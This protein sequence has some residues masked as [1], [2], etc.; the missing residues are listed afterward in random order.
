MSSDQLSK[1]SAKIK[2]VYIELKDYR[3]FH[4][5]YDES[6]A[7]DRVAQAGSP[8]TLDKTRDRFIGRKAVKERIRS[9]LGHTDT[10]SGSYLI[11]GFRGM[12]K[13]SVIRQAIEEYNDTIDSN[14][15]AL[16]SDRINKHDK[17]LKSARIAII[18]LITTALAITGWVFSL[19]FSTPWVQD[20]VGLIFAVITGLSILI[21]TLHVRHTFTA[22]NKLEVDY[23]FLVPWNVFRL[24]FVIL[25]LIFIGYVFLSKGFLSFSSTGATAVFVIL[26]RLVLA[27]LVFYI[28][29]SAVLFVFDFLGLVR[30]E[31]YTRDSVTQPAEDSSVKSPIADRRRYEKF[32]IN[33]SQDSLDEMDVLRRM[34]IAIEDYWS[35]NRYVFDNTNFDR[36]LYRPWHFFI[37]CINRPREE[38]TAASYKSVLS[39]LSGLRMRMSGQV[40]TRKESRF[41]PNLKADIAGL[42]ELAMPLGSFSNNDEIVF[43]VANAKEAEYQL[44]DILD[45]IDILR[46]T[47][48]PKIPLF[49]F[50]ID[51]LDK[52]EPHTP[53]VK[54]GKETPIIDLNLFDP[55]TD[56][57]R[58]RREAVGKLLANL[59]GFLSVA[60]AKMFFIGGRE[61][62]DADLADI[63]D[64]ESFYSSIFNDVIYVES[65]FKDSS[66]ESGRGSGG[67]T[68]MTEAYVCKIILNDLVG[69]TEQSKKPNLE[70]L[71]NFLTS[72]LDGFLRFDGGTER[73]SPI[74]DLEDRQKRYKVIFTLQNFIIFLTYRSN[75]T[76]K[77]LTSLTESLIVPGPVLANGHKFFRDNLVILHDPVN[78]DDKLDLSGRLFLKFNFTTQYEIGVTANL[79]RPY[80]ITN[81][82]HLKALGDKLLFSSS[83]IIDHILKFHPFAF[84][85]RDLELIPE[86]VLV[87]REPHLREFIDDLIRF[88]SLN[89]IRNTVSGLFE[90]RFRSIIRRDLIHLSKTSDLSAAAFNF[91]L[92]ESL[93][94]KQ[95]YK[96][97]LVELRE[98]YKGAVPVERDNQFVHSL[99]FVQTIL[100][101]LHFYDKEYDAAILYYTESIQTLRLPDAV[102]DLRITRHQFLIWLRNELKLGL[103]LEKIRAYDSAFS[104]YKTLS[105]DTDR[106]LR[107]LVRNARS[108]D[109]NDIRNLYSP[110][111]DPEE[112]EDHRTI[113]LVSMP[114]V[115]LLAVTEKA[116]LDGITYA[117]L[118]A[119]R[120]SFLRTI[121]AVH[122]I[123]PRNND[124]YRKTFLQ[125]DYYNNVGSILY[126][127][128]CQFPKVFA[129]NTEDMSYLL[130]AVA[131][132]G[133]SHPLLRAQKNQYRQAAPKRR[134][135]NDE[136]GR[137]ADPS[138]GYDQISINYFPA[139]TP[140]N[141]YW[142]SLY[143]LLTTNV[144][145]L[146]REINAAKS[147]V[148]SSPPGPV[149]QNKGNV[150]GSKEP[151]EQ[152]DLLALTCGYLLPGCHDLVSDSRLFYLANVISKIGDSILASL[153]RGQ[154]NLSNVTYDPVRLHN[155]THA[156]YSETAR[157]D[158]LL[159][160]KSPAIKEGAGTDG[161]VET[162]RFSVN[163]WNDGTFPYVT[164]VLGT[165]ATFQALSESDVFQVSTVLH[166][167]ELAAALFHKSGQ[168]AYYSSQLMRILYVVKDVVELNKDKDATID[169]LFLLFSPCT[170]DKP[171]TDGGR[172]QV[173]TDNKSA[174]QQ[175]RI[176]DRLEEIAMTIIRNT[177]WNNE[178][179]NRPQ[180]Q[181]YK[182][183]FNLHGEEWAKDRNIIYSNISNISDAKEA[184]LLVESIKLKLAR[185]NDRNFI[186]EFALGKNITSAYGSVNNRYLRM[187][188]LKYR[189]E[190][191]YYILKHVMNLPGL[192]RAPE[193]FTISVS[194]PI[195]N[196]SELR[197]IID[198]MTAIISGTK[199]D[200]RASDPTEFRKFEPV[201]IRVAVEFVIK[202]ALFCSRQLINMIRLYD[203]GYVIGYSFI[204]AAHS[205]MGDWCQAYENHIKLTTQMP[206]C[207]MVLGEI[208]ILEAVLGSLVTKVNLARASTTLPVEIKNEMIKVA[209]ELRG[210]I[211]AFIDNVKSWC[212]TTTP[213]IENVGAVTAVSKELRARLNAVTD[214]IKSWCARTTTLIGET[215]GASRIT[216]TL[217]ARIETF[218]DGM[219]SLYETATA[220]SNRATTLSEYAEKRRARIN[221][222]TGE[223]NSS[224]ANIRTL[225]D[226]A[227]VVAA[228]TQQHRDANSNL[229]DEIK[230]WSA[231]TKTLTEGLRGRREDF[232][233]ETN[234]WF[235]EAKTFNGEL[236]VQIKNF[237]DEMKW[238]C[239]T[240]TALIEEINAISNE[241]GLSGRTATALIEEINAIPVVIDELQFL[242]ESQQL[243]EDATALISENGIRAE[244]SEGFDQ[245]TKESPRFKEEIQEM[246]G[247]ETLLFL[248]PK[249]HYETA[250]LFYRKM[251][252]LHSDGKSY[253][254]KLHD[255][256]MLEDDYNDGSAHYSIAAERLRINTGDIGSKMVDLNAK[257]ANSDLYKYASYFARHP[258]AKPTGTFAPGE[259]IRFTEFLENSILDTPL[260]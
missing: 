173:A 186:K 106:Y 169:R 225:I 81:S 235:A 26:L 92:D 29:L 224:C 231:K 79:Y 143:H 201:S 117:N 208:E 48:E 102:S 23:L 244:E 243:T 41:S 170:A 64:R 21:G 220:L 156:S 58:Q 113:Q 171:H 160:I 104:L 223:I 125:A 54:E 119:N 90:Y 112:A 162:E 132:R 110:E 75:G 217:R 228:F 205:R 2:N 190:R 236:G 3:F 89:Y 16:D 177:T 140:L 20:L 11:T 159:D 200:T 105:L 93:S 95:H 258:D 154:S 37:T 204:A 255:I 128:N 168:N 85:W 167:Y 60:K 67:I 78:I 253:R 19:K 212:T 254:D 145:R 115:A 72:N 53:T 99:C 6:V 247:T 126:Y 82:R 252:Q 101:D 221:M 187:L 166:I 202:E 97:K 237:T 148:A 121:N 214:G 226:G 183:T 233:K 65:F 182:D 59:K 5:P 25:L 189:S 206:G 30:R 15:S 232:T 180:I 68:Q 9:I 24:A 210:L 70:Q 47:Q 33:L 181:K 120:A 207:E 245:A 66:D 43:P 256:Y 10:K 134:R 239:S 198:D 18:Y 73:L 218:T 150:S 240:V 203:P 242:F 260:N 111:A 174:M 122:K 88:Y 229:T 165:I 179:S 135:G 103:T 251:I 146:S 213:L 155:L 49:A 44:R 147:L 86:V 222:F 94:V 131:D 12:G 14:L 196:R 108:D 175:L 193:K 32:E 157:T 250:L 42:A 139:L 7:P 227:D 100:G 107:R 8:K 209:E 74:R 172:K 129:Y 138:G 216:K 63:S 56:R 248:E 238:W 249:N 31:Y 259:K 194:T 230:S 84:S 61:M 199:S 40:T 91:T 38:N 161:Q 127:K 188:E 35:K 69:N 51:E 22:H 17:Y 96:R 137:H 184:V 28:V 80:L 114:F 34:T 52:I 130:D 36:K 27:L 118:K 241:F 246:L 197:Q 195:A 153:K 4:S 133:H 219:K 192:F 124:E 158:N 149:G 176:Y 215:N 257:L 57:F 163:A 98:K 46:S 1:Y 123:T 211:E 77:K 191:C 151:V 109:N 87:T 39:K 83:F 164:A 142:N 116:R 71:Y 55:D 76:P 141:Y 136:G 13:T 50:I 62:F 152:D 178:V 234:L 185:N 45:D 144:D